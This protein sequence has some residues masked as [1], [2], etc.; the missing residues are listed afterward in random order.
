M[1]RIYVTCSPARQDSKEGAPLGGLV[2]V[3]EKEWVALDLGTHLWVQS[4]LRLKTP[5]N[6]FYNGKVGTDRLQFTL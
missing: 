3:T 2:G 4:S 1:N 5:D 6:R